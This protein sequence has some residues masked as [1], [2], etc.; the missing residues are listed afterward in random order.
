MKRGIA[1]LCYPFPVRESHEIRQGFLDFFAGKGHKVVPSAPLVP[2]ADPSL[3][4]INAGMAPMKRYFEGKEAPPAPR[5][6]SCQ[7]CVRTVDIDRVGFTNRHNTFF[8]MLGNFSFG[9]YFK[10][11]AIEYA[12]EFLTSKQWAGLDPKYLYVT[13]H[14]NDPEAPGLWEKVAGVSRDRIFGLGDEHN[15]WAAGDTGPCG[16]DTEIFFDMRRAEKNPCKDADDFVRMTDEGRMMEVWNLVFME[17]NRDEAGTLTPLPKKNI[18]T[19][20]GLERFTMVLQGKSNVYECDLFAYLVDYFT[21]LAAAA[22][23]PERVKVEQLAYNPYWLCADHM[24]TAAFL[25]ADNITPSNLDRGYVLRR[26]I[27]R[28]VK[29]AYLLGVRK[30]FLRDA[31]QLVIAKMGSAYPE[32]QSRSESILTWLAREEEGFLGVLERGVED[33]EREFTRNGGTVSGK[34][35]FTLHDTYGFP[36]EVTQ[37]LARLRG[38][39]VDE[40][41]FTAEMEAQRQ[42]GRD[43]K[44]FNSN[45]QVEEGAVET[46]A[47]EFLGYDVLAAPAMVRGIKPF[48][49]KMEAKEKDSAGADEAK[50]RELFTLYTD[51]TPFYAEVGGQPGDMGWALAGNAKMRI[52]DS[53]VKGEHIGF[54]AEGGPQDMRAG[55]EVQLAVDEPRRQAIMRAHTTAHAMLAALKQVLGDHIN[56]A[57]SQIYPDR[58][59]FDFS[60]YEAVSPAQLREMERIVNEMILADYRVWT[61]ELPLVQAK[62]EGVTAV[63]DEKYGEV[64]RVVNIGEEGAQVSRE[65]CGGTHMTRSAQAGS[66]VV[67]KEESV[68]SG[69]RRIEGAVGM[70]AVKF[71]ATFREVSEELMREFHV[72]LNEVTLTVA[73]VR[74]ELRETHEEMMIL[75]R[76]AM[77]LAIADRV[78]KP[79]MVGNIA[80]VVAGLEG[81]T[82]DDVKTVVERTARELV[83]AGKSPYAV[84]IVRKE[85]KSAG[86]TLKFSSDLIPRGLKAG[87][88]VRELAKLMGGGGGGSDEFAEAGGK[89]ASKMEDVV[90]LLRSK[91]ASLS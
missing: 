41:E 40:A 67:V 15:M 87:V 35:A 71:L 64:V 55:V 90:T 22:T 68:Q 17:F 2:L 12:W 89:D 65:L 54:F 21:N 82:K 36:F 18:D 23:A 45:F 51:R 29:T 74:E 33:L 20:A 49:G 91:L 3:L 24:R 77:Y 62:R 48:A 16:Y 52:V 80:L 86:L 46:G 37:E 39:E 69:I 43:A 76:N 10:A 5:A 32:L 58:I 8:E 53:R 4:L 56:Q 7:K 61:Q 34:F 73:K 72:P 47:V 26:I 63:F 44:E 60:H 30:T 84:M 88:M 6:A 50:G 11:E 31:A 59:R 57:G 19:G 38:Y 1:G 75:R 25:L 28:V 70:E 9:D 13:T 81:A 83:K 78:A 42:R 66:F 14:K 79:E 27:R 85:E